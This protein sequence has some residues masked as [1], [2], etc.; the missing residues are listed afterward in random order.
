M[1]LISDL[2]TSCRLEL[3]DTGGSPRWTDAEFLGYY[4]Q[5]LQEVPT[6]APDRVA[7]PQ[8]LNFV[9]GAKQ[10]LPSTIRALVSI[11]RNSNGAACTAFDLDILQRF[12]PSWVEG[13]TSATVVQYA[14]DPAVPRTVYVNPPL[15]GAVV[16]ESIVVPVLTAAAAVGEEVAIADDVIPAAKNYMMYRACFKDAED[17]T[18]ASKADHYYSRMTQLLGGT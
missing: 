7:Q 17:T 4:N 2:I 10:T 13:P 3:I 8:N 14:Y 11:I 5:F 6:L 18:M 1:A 15:A 9:A 16:V 12:D